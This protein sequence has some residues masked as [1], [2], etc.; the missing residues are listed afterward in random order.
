MDTFSLLVLTHQ[1]RL[2]P[3]FVIK[4]NNLDRVVAATTESRLKRNLPGKEKS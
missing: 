4:K 1:P 2:H 3:I